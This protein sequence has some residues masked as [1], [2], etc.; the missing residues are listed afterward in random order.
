MSI[1]QSHVAS[2]LYL[3]TAICVCVFVRGTCPVHSHSIVSAFVSL[4]LVMVVYLLSRI[5]IYT[6]GEK[7]VGRDDCLRIVLY[8]VTMPRI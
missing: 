7:K 4:I 3:M 2:H 1:S 8:S 5:S 6:F